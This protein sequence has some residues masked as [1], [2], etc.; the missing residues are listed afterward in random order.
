LAQGLKIGQA[1]KIQEEKEE[2]KGTFR[3]GDVQ[4]NII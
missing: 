3:K 2:E 4:K 1:R